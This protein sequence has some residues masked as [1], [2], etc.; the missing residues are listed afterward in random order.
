[1]SDLGRYNE[2][3]WL[4]YWPPIL[5]N[6]Y[7]IIDLEFIGQVEMKFGDEKLFW[8]SMPKPSGEQENLY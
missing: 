4:R 6:P 7:T 5:S 1:M 3:L 8:A 2:D